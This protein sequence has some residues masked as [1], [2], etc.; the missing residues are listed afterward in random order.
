MSLS[1]KN[2]YNVEQ[3]CLAG[4]GVSPS[5]LAGTNTQATNLAEPFTSDG[6]LSAGTYAVMWRVAGSNVFYVQP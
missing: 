5:V 2:V 4:A 3:I 6:T 1:E